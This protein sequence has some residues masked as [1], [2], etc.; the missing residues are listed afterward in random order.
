MK[1][2][3]YQ[4]HVVSGTVES[5]YVSSKGRNLFIKLSGD[6]PE[7]IQCTSRGGNT[8]PIEGSL[9]LVSSKDVVK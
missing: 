4:G 9:V 5:T 2:Y 3:N 8:W 6:I 7:E 1:Q